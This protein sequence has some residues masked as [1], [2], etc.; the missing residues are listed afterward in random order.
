MDILQQLD[1]LQAVL[2]D[3]APVLWSYYKNLIDEGFSEEQ[4]LEL[5]KDVQSKLFGR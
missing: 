4:A 5:T 3:I 1:Q 2:R